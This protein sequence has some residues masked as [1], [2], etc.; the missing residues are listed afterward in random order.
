MTNKLITIKIDKHSDCYFGTVNNGVVKVFNII[1]DL[2]TEQIV[3]VG[4]VFTKKFLFYEKPINSKKLNILIVNKLSYDFMLYCI[5][6]IITKMLVF[7]SYGGD[8]NNNIA[9]PILHTNE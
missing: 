9:M 1:K 6:Y 8:C 3:I 7:K 2:I 5:N 4:K